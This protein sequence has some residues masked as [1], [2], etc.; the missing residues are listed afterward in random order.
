MVELAASTD[1]IRQGER[2]IRSKEALFG[3]LAF[4]FLSRK[5]LES[6]HNDIAIKRIDLHEQSAASRLL[7][8]DERG[9]AAAEQVQHILAATRGI[10]QGVSGQLYRL[11]GEVDHLLGD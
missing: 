4:G 8:G 2:H 7:G 5:L 9:A 1:L 3:C 10:L 6:P 11:F